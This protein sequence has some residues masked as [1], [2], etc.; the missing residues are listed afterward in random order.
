M[1]VRALSLTVCL[2]LLS[3]FLAVPVFAQDE[4]PDAGPAALSL[5]DPGADPVGFFTQT[6]AFVKSG[7]GLPIAAALVYLL[8]FLLRK[9]AVTKRIAFFGTRAGGWFLALAIPVLMGLAHAWLAGESLA[10]SLITA[11]PIAALAITAYQAV[12][13][14]KQGAAEVLR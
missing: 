11:L 5:P 4:A 2:A 10:A 7:K 14:K 12:K 13:D 1:R 3:V 6:Y 8:V 9:P